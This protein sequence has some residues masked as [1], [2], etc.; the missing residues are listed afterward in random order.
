MSEKTK[1]SF[2]DK[3][4]PTLIKK[5][6]VTLIP[7]GAIGY[8]LGPTLALLGNSVLSAYFNKYMSDALHVNEW[9]KGFFTWLPVISVIFVVIGNILVGR[10]MDNI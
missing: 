10:L 8:L 4:P 5:N 6:N 9:A 7:E 2:F 3:L 1:G